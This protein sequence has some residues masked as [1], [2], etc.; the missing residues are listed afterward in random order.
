MTNVASGLYW[1]PMAVRQCEHAGEGADIQLRLGGKT[2]PASG[3]PL[4]SLSKRFRDA[5]FSA[6]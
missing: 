3:E 1:D 4:E 5:T 2:E 6:K